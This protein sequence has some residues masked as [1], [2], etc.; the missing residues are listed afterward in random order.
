MRVMLDTNIII[1]AMVFKSSRM[2]EVL[3][4]IREKHELCLSA[5][6]IEETKRIL[7]D[8]FSDVATDIE[9]FFE[10][11]P[12]TLIETPINNGAPLVRIRD[13]KDYPIVHAAIIAQIDVL[14]TGD[15][16]FFDVEI[17]CPLILSPA[18]FMLR[19]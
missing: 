15:K 12:Y 16:D 11:Y 19:Y 2:S 1:S 9:R 18:D 17:D 6:S 10:D 14:V 4:K 7:N 13:K 8:K 5:Y 3:G